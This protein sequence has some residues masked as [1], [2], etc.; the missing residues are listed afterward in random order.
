MSESR[1]P[2]K[3]TGMDPDQ[4]ENFLRQFVRYF[5]SLKADWIVIWEALPPAEGMKDADRKLW[6]TIRDAKIRESIKQ[7][8]ELAGKDDVDEPSIK[9]FKRTMEACACSSLRDFL[10]GQALAM[11]PSDYS[12]DSPLKLALERLRSHESREFS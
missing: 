9:A 8:L 4:L 11:V 10:G 6:N 1:A 5:T 2:T 3:Y 12:E 7:K